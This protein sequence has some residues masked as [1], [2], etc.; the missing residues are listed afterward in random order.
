[1]YGKY[2][3]LGTIARFRRKEQKQ[4]LKAALKEEERIS[5][6]AEKVVKWVK[7]EYA[8]TDVSS[9]ENLKWELGL[10]SEPFIV[11]RGPWNME[12]LHGCLKQR[13]LATKKRMTIASTKNKK[14]KV[15]KQCKVSNSLCQACSR[16]KC[17]EDL[18]HQVLK[19]SLSETTKIAQRED[20]VKKL[21]CHES[22][23][24]LIKN[25]GVC[26]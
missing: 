3:F 21:T 9:I 14:N 26:I 16:A 7:Q 13:R 2:D 6:Q 22:Y 17:H 12:A 4:R 24:A 20:E 25:N 10:H 1:M 5:R 23:A 18:Q 19:C 15:P 11:G 8:R